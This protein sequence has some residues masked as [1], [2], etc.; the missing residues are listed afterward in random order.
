MSGGIGRQLTA[1]AFFIVITA[2]LLTAYAG[3][4]SVKAD[5]RASLRAY[6]TTSPNSWEPMGFNVSG[7]AIK[8]VIDN[9]GWNVTKTVG[10]VGIGNGSIG[11]FKM[12]S[13]LKDVNYTDKNFM[14]G[15]VSTAPWDPARL[16]NRIVPESNATSANNTTEASNKTSNVTNGE[17]SAA[18]A[19]IGNLTLTAPG[20]AA[21]D[22]NGSSDNA[23][24]TEVAG[25]RMALD[26]PYHSIL[27]G[28]PADDLMYEYPHALQTSMY[29]RL[30][31][32]RMP[33]GSCMSIGMRTLGYGY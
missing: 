10:N 9:L 27:F 28:R 24:A 13:N 18:N 2:L 22:S 1:A 14:A 31:G 30:V 33:C 12:V 23:T 8:T 4:T 17:N 26:D 20:K 11:A 7:T 29:A 6:T 5:A 16:S 19:G 15:D 25:A 32:L 21:N 3:M